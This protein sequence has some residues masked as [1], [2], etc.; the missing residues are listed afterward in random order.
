M[1]IDLNVEPPITHVQ[2]LP[3]IHCVGIARQTQCC[4][5]GIKFKTFIYVEIDSEH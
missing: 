5:V 4:I 2:E 3:T 1:N